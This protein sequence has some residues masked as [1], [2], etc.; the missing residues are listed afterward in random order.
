MDFRVTLDLRVSVPDQR[1]MEKYESVDPYTV[2]QKFQHEGEIAV[3]ELLQDNP[4]AGG[5][6]ITSAAVTVVPSYG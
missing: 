4:N 1:A 6:R 3:A 5:G 2:S